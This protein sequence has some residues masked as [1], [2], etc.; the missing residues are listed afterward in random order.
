MSN[1][2]GVTINQQPQATMDAATA[3]ADVGASAASASAHGADMEVVPGAQPDR[4][5]SAMSRRWRLTAPYSSTFLNHE[6]QSSAIE[7]IGQ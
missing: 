3:F 4:R 2:V 7:S 6:S 1:E 5:L